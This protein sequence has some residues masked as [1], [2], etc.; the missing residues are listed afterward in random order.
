MVEFL[1]LELS[2]IPLLKSYF[3]P[4]K[5]RLCDTTLGGAVMWRKS[6]QT[7]YA[8]L[9]DTLLMRSRLSSGEWAYTVP[10]GDVEAGVSALLEYCKER[11]EALVFTSVSESD[12]ERLLSLLPQFTAS[13]L[14]DWSDYLY[15][16]ESLA[17]LRG[18][19]LSGQ[20]NHKNFFLKQHPD[21][22]F[23]SV[24]KEN[25]SEIRAF[26]EHYYRINSKDS[27]YFHQEADAVREVLEHLDEYGFFGGLIRTEGGICAFSL[28][29]VV[30]DTLFVHVE[31]ADRNVRGAYQM[32]V[33]EFV[34]H[35]AADGVRF[36]NREE[37]LGDPGLRF[38]K[39]SYHPIALLTKYSLKR[40]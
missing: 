9:G 38:A 28:G 7:E 3:L 40:G 11:G 16:A 39:E 20:R 26:L 33:S 15:E 36:V 1:K 19:K 30:G 18:K 22:R 10:L 8:L 24:G 4:L 32:M 5:T 34:S 14:R 35:F 37:D 29:E 23:E 31:K 12:K 13:A 25:L 6:F 17:T 21:W 2:E 27:E